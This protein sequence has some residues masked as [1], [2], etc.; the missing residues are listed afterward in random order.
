MFEIKMSKSEMFVPSTS[1]DS[2]RL[3][4]FRTAVI[5]ELKWK[6]VPSDSARSNRA[7]ERVPT[8][9]LICQAPNACSIK[10]IVK[11]APGAFL[12]SEPV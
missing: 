3:E 2:I 8:P 7:L 4:L 11:S 10:G 5:E 1:I 6:S 9:P 12:G